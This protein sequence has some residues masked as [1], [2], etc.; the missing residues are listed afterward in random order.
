MG[1]VLQLP[2]GVP[3]PNPF[4]FGVHTHTNTHA[5]LFLPLQGQQNLPF[6]PRSA[7]D[8]ALGAWRAAGVRVGGNAAP[9][10]PLGWLEL[11]WARV[12]VGSRSPATPPQYLFVNIVPDGSTKPPQPGAAPSPSPKPPPPRVHLPSAPFFNK[13][14]MTPPWCPWLFLLALLAHRSHSPGSTPRI[15]QPGSRTPHP[16]PA[17]CA[18]SRGRRRQLGWHIPAWEAGGGSEVTER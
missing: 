12:A 6:W 4:L 1:R 7:A 3:Q 11:L 8:E 2:P 18:R 17:R 14:F 15:L 9:P 5:R 16:L 10:C 13:R